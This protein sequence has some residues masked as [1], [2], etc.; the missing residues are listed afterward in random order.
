MFVV[1]GSQEAVGNRELARQAAELARKAGWPVETHVHEGGHTF[2]EDWWE[3]FGRAM[4]WL[5]ADG[6]KPLAKPA[7]PK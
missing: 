4:D 1:S 7:A 5:A 2:P 3:V 6:R